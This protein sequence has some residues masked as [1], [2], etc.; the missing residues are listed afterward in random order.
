MLRLTRQPFFGTSHHCPIVA[1][2]FD[3][4]HPP[5]TKWNSPVTSMVISYKRLLELFCLFIILVWASQLVLLDYHLLKN[6]QVPLGWDYIQHYAASRLVLDGNSPEAYDPATI[7]SIEAQVAGFRIELAPYFLIWNY[8]P[9]FLLVVAPLSLLPYTLSLLLWLS[10]TF[11]L[12]AFIVSRIFRDHLTPMIFTSFPAVF[13]TFLHGQNSFFFAS[14]LGGGLL[15]LESRPILAGLLLGILSCKPQLFLVIPFALLA[16][17]R[18]IALASIAA[19]TAVLVIASLLFFGTSTWEAF[20]ANAPLLRNILEAGHA[21]YTQVLT[22]YSSVRMLGLPPNIAFLVQALASL[23]GIALIGYVWYFNL[24]IELRYA[25]LVAVIALAS[26]YLLTHDMTILAIGM[27]Y[28]YR[29]MV[30]RGTLP[31][32]RLMIACLWGLPLVCVFVA[33]YTHFQSAPLI[34][35]AFAC[36]TVRRA[37]HPGLS[38][39]THAQSVS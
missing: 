25:V 16:G 24:A 35:A 22:T 33:N 32:E 17:R 34:I 20:F 10:S 37:N 21:P 5:R 28:F 30:A 9:T 1:V 29:D 19:T 36:L 39:K 2:R 38:N 12:C 8:P 7:G 18:W 11:A 26:P 14:A 4:V 27:A 31:Y 6:N 13:W 3:N 23:F 15:L